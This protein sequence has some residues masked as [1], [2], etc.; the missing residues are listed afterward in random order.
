MLINLFNT[1]FLAGVLV[2]VTYTYRNVHKLLFLLRKKNF[3]MVKKKVAKSCFV[4]CHPFKGNQYQYSTKYQRRTPLST[5][6]KKNQVQTIKRLTEKDFK[7][8]TKKTLDGR[9]YRIIGS[10]GDNVSEN[11]INV[12]LLRPKTSGSTS[13][14]GQYLK[15]DKNDSLVSEMRLISKEKMSNMFNT[16][17]KEHGET[18]CDR[19]SLAVLKEKKKGLCWEQILGCKNCRYK[20]NSF[21]LYDEA[22]SATRYVK[23]YC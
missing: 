18:G 1:S 2:F 3:K 21:K 5:K 13:V 17:I 9:S 22:P 12:M 15:K 16:C 8:I 19:I 20:S 14:S 11:E 6:H 7:R 10:S 4:K 23:H